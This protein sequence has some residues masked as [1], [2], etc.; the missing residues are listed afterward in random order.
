MEK[1][2]KIFEGKKVLVSKSGEYLTV[3]NGKISFTKNKNMAYTFAS[4]EEAIQWEDDNAND[5]DELTYIKDA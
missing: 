1:F 3:K 4:E 5:F 2:R